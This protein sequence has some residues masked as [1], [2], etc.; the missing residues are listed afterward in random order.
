M[1]MGNNAKDVFNIIRTV[2]IGELR[3]HLM[4]PPL[5]LVVGPDVQR[6]QQFAFAL[7]GSDAPDE[8]AARAT[9]TVA[10]PDVLDGLQ[11]GP[12]PY[13]AVFL[14][15]PTPAIR[16]HPL[17]RRFVDQQRQTALLAVLTGP[18]AAFDPGIPTIA[19]AN[20]SDPRALHALRL[21]LVPMLHAD[22]RAAWG[23]AFAGFRQ[24]VTDSLI[25]QTARANAQFAVV[26]DL[27]AR[28]PMFGQYAAAGADFL[29]LTKNQMILA[30]QLAAIHG[31]DLDD[32]KAALLNAAPFLIAGL[33]WRELAHRAVQL[34]PGA[35]LVPKAVIAY[36]GTVVSGMMARALA[37]PEGVRAWLDGVQQGT[38]TSLGVGNARLQA[39]KGRVAAAAGS[40]GERIGERTHR[41]PRWQRAPKLGLDRE[42]PVRVIPATSLSAD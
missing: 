13:D 2:Q 23:R 32:Q 17:V 28:I 8:Q 22:R 34:V 6:A 21:R 35:P 16:H 29:I 19:V 40:I 4:Q 31:R 30:Y 11:I 27:T 10:T 33:G 1:S 37:N 26:A 42:P 18:G 41:I 38:K 3:E 36:G 24:P 15:D 9:M 20:L 25:E 7:A 5:A 39:V 14:L 12:V